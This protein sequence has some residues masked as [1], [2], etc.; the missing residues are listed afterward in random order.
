MT[1]RDQVESAVRTALVDAL[2]VDPGEVTSE[3]KIMV[4]LGAESI[5]VL[6]IRF[7]LEEALK[8]TITDDLLRA[9]FEAEGD[10]G[11]FKELFTVGGLCDW[12][13]SL[14]EKTDD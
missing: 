2:E 11:D 14:L 10:A 1:I 12:L 9:S 7:R 8:V 6:D 5:D 3:A 13:V 4:D